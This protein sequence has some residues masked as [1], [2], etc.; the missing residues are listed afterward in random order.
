MAEQFV[1]NHGIEMRWDE[2][3]CQN[4][5]EITEG[6]TFYQV[7][8]EDEQSIGAKLN[9]MEKYNVGGVAAW[10]LGFEKP[11]IWDVIADYVE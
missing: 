10:R 11:S 1:A 5:G 4:Y 6:E 8:L 3:T 9:I 7:W 2:E